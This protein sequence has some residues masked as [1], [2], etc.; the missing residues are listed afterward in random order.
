MYKLVRKGV[1]I[2]AIAEDAGVTVKVAEKTF[3]SAFKVIREILSE[4]EN[5]RILH[6]G[7]FKLSERAAR[8]GNHPKTGEKIMIPAKNYVTFK[9]FKNLKESVNA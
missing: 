1:L 2:R 8:E 7:E 6:F 4:G 5:V 9:P 3:N